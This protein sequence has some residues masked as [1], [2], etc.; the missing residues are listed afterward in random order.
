M[1]N[2]DAVKVVISKRGYALYFSRAPIPWERDNFPLGEDGK[3]IGE[4]FR[5]VGIYGYRVG[6]LQEYLTWEPCPLEKLESL[7]QLRV[8]WNGGRIHVDIAKQHV[9]IG[10][11]TEDDLAVVRELI[12]TQ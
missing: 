8:L 3:L 6:F 5:H 9:P 1:L 7:E 4:H 2:P 11:D 10:V 12:Y